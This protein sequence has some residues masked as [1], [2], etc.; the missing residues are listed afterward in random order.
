MAQPTYLDPELQGIERERQLAQA[1]QQ[2]GMQPLQGQVVGNRFVAPS[3]TQQLAN[4]YDIYSGGQRMAAAENKMNQY[5]NAQQALAQQNI[6]EA[7]RLAKGSPEETVYGAGEQGPTKTVIPAQVGNN[8]MA[9]A[10]LLRPNATGIETT[11]GTKLLEQQFK[12]PAW[13][14]VDLVDPKTQNTMRGIWDAN[15]PNPQST[16]RPMGVGKQAIAPAELARLQ[17]EGIPVPSGIGGMGGATAAPA[18]GGQPNYPTVSPTSPVLAKP[19]TSIPM[20]AGLSP[21]QQQEWRAKQSEP[22]TG[23]AADRVTGAVQYQDALNNYYNA[24]KDLSTKDMANPQTRQLVQEK[25][26]TVVLTGKN[27]H[28][29]GVLNGGDERILTGLVP[30]FNNITGFKDTIKA[31]TE[32]QKEFAKNA[33]TSTYATHQKP[34]PANLQQVFATQKTE[35]KSEAK[36]QS[37]AATPAFTWDPQTGTWK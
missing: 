35:A 12:E 19:D 33:I 28:S 4:A 1:L 17:F 11:L 16:F 27:A 20:P 7:L 10:K 37:R 36:P 9:I 21:K 14:E 29:L 6:A 5:Q 25:Y 22:L 3:W 18:M 26:N 8:Q 34:V 31:T 2:R 23:V 32:G 15:S 24:I 30:N 13:K